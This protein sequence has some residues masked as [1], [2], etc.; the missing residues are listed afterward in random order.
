METAPD[1]T[2]RC[3]EEVLLKRLGGQVLAARKK[4]GLSRRALSERSAISPR[5]LA[6]LEA[7]DGNISIRLL[8]RVS[9]ALGLSMASLLRGAET[10]PDRAQRICLIGLRGAGKSTLGAAA[11]R[12]LGLPFMQ[13]ND[14][15]EADSGMAVAEVM[16]LY[17]PE[18]YR[19]L[20]AQALEKIAAAHDR[21]ILEVAGGIVSDP[22]TYAVLLAQFHTIWLRTSPDEHMAR[23]R[24]QGDERPMAGNPQAL[25]DLRALLHSREVLYARAEVE[26]DTA[27]KTPEASLRDVLAA[28]R[29]A[30]FLGATV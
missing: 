14:A 17:G 8:H 1:L 5:Y 22:D 9:E 11:A 23:V 4:L 6:Q 13:L 27:G 29:T 20:E 3:D 25:A 28:I 21:L 18:G 26:I 10:H 24:A 12:D 16:A 19:R 15:I 30:G 2:R 7:G